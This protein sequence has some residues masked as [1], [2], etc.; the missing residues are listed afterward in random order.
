MLYGFWRMR[1]NC[2]A[3]FR[4]WLFFARQKNPAGLTMEGIQAHPHCRGHKGSWEMRR[5]GLWAAKQQ[6]I[7]LHVCGR[8][9]GME[10][11]DIDT[12]VKCLT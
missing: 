4:A 6:R 10:G 8:A 1:G 2:F 12:E 11:K 9:A 5:L 7:P 3:F